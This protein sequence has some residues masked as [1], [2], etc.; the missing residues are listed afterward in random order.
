MDWNSWIGKRIFVKLVDGAVYTGKVIDV[1]GVFF[2]IIDKFGENVYF[3]IE[4]IQ[5]IKE[6]RN[7]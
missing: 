3:R 1:D 7:G 6:E 2:S 4:N 5:K